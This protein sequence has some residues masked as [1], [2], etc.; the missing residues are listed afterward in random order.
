MSE[1]EQERVLC[2]DCG[3]SDAVC[4][5][6]V[7]MGEHVT[8]RRLC[9]ACMAKATM[10][11]AAGNLGKV[12]GAIMAAAHNAAQERSQAPQEADAS[13]PEQPREADAPQEAPADAM[14][15]PRC[16]M[17]EMQ[18]RRDGRLG[19]MQCCDTF[20]QQLEETL[21]RNSPQLCH[22]GRRPLDNE[23]AM[24]SRARQEEMQRLLDAAVAREEYEKAAE[25]RDALR[26]MRAEAQGNE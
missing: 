16:G 7:M 17:T 3:Q 10:S 20:R 8:H 2:E 23:A 24:R 6:A 21:R 4:T 15:C 14:A 9:Q 25:L 1:Y 13:L 18:F 11:I 12:L 26:S 5:V 19:C 22:T